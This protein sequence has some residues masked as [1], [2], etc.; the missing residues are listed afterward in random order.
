MTLQ[1]T[2]VTKLDLHGNP[3]MSAAGVTSIVALFP[4]LEEINLAQCT[5]MR[6]FPL[7][8]AYLSQLH[9]LDLSYVCTTARTLMVLIVVSTCSRFADVVVVRHHAPKCVVVVSYRG[10]CGVQDAPPGWLPHGHP[11]LQHLNLR[12]N[13]RL[14]D[15]D[16]TAL[17]I[18]FPGLRSLDLRHCTAL[19]VY[20][21]GLFDHA[22]LSVPLAVA[23]CSTT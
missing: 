21:F 8:T 2:T 3:T 19:E 9:T 22:Q 10:A 1:N 15:E 12:H 7:G 18:A 16:I 23:L 6:T 14:Q 5:G 13:R 11:S 17:A 20:P 4:C